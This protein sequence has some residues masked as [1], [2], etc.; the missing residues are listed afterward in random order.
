MAT[1]KPGK[2]AP[3]RSLRPPV[4]KRPAPISHAPRGRDCL[5]PREDLEADREDLLAVARIGRV[6]GV[7]GHVTVRLYNP[8]SDCAWADDV[9]W[10][11]GEGMPITPV[12]IDE[13]SDKG[14]K[15]L[16]RFEGVDNPQD[17]KALTH[18]ELLVPTEWLTEPDE[19]EFHIHE[20]RGMA[21][22][23]TERGPLGALYDVFD[24]GAGD[25]WVVRGPQGEHM[26]PAVKDVILGVDR[27]TRTISVR[28]D[29]E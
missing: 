21:V 27:E 28:F 16:V 29:S 3:G 10:V 5:V 8:D 15:L 23:D 25:I 20:L 12:A 2:P 19:D 24:A 6:W 7:R 1:R 11:R 13:W 17:G 4:P 18:L 14:G 26:L 22:V 9:V